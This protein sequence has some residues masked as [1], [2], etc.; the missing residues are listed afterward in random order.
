MGRVREELIDAMRADLGACLI[1]L[2][3]D[4]TLAPIVA[5]PGTSRLAPGA[6]EALSA[7]AAAGARVAVITG[8]DAATA[9]RLS[10]LDQLDGL[11]VEGLYGAERWSRGELTSPP[12]PPAMKQVRAQLPAVVERATRTAGAARAGEWIE[13]KRLS[14]VVHTRRAGEPAAALAALERPVTELG[15]RIGVEVHAGRD[16]LELRLPGFDKGRALRGLVDELAPRAV[17]YAG[18]DVGDLPAF[19][20]LSELRRDGPVTWSVGVVDD[21]RGEVAVATDLQ[22]AGPADVVALLAEIAAKD[23]IDPGSR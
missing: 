14:L 20:Y 10:G 4:G 11:L 12:E 13:D 16:V 9:V 2:D 15:E 1:A 23:R 7:L 6:A 22:L 8:R 3:F 17:L 5:D 21:H 19:R 18:D